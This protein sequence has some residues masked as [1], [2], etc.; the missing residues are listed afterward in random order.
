MA[1]ANASISPRAL[2][3]IRK[4]HVAVVTLAQREAKK[5][6]QAQLRAQGLKPQHFTMREISLLAEDYFTEHRA[7]LIAEALAVVNTS[8]YFSQ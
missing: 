1:E 8:P 7:E 4:H 2:E 3:R 6:V 5:A